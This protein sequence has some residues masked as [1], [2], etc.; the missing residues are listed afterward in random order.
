MYL[1]DSVSLLQYSQVA[2]GHDNLH[3]LSG[4]FPPAN[5]QWAWIQYNV[6]TIM[7]IHTVY[8]GC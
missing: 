1:T 3:V 5:S 4:K 8:K 6:C 7:Y 2:S